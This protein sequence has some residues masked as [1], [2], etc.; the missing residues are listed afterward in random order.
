MAVDGGRNENEAAAGGGHCAGDD[1]DFDG[2]AA[3][4]IAD[5]SQ[6]GA[7]NEGNVSRRVAKAVLLLL[8]GML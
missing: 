8:I 1:G 7:A 2:L 5:P 3:P 4:L 6:R